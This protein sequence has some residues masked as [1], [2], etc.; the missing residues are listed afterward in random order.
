LNRRGV[1]HPCL[2][3]AHLLLFQ[4]V[5]AAAG[6][7]PFQV[8]ET[9]PLRAKEEEEVEILPCLVEEGEEEEEESPPC[10]EEAGEERIFHDHIREAG[11]EGIRLCLEGEEGADSRRLYHLGET[12]S[13]CSGV[14]AGGDILP[15]QEGEEEEE[16]RP[17]F[18]SVG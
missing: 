11:E 16:E 17:D 3:E 10:R 13:L 18:R 5:V 1:S 12:E 15:F 2:V 7:L 9:G 8:E 14:K 4:A 6:T